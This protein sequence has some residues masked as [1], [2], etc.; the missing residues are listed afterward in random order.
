MGERPSDAQRGARE[1]GRRSDGAPLEPLPKRKRV[2]GLDDTAAAD[3]RVSTGSGA[4]FEPIRT[5]ETYRRDHAKLAKRPVRRLED[6]GLKV[7]V[8]AA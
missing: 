2:T 3:E 1:G 7:T 6:L 4:A 5:K 8:S